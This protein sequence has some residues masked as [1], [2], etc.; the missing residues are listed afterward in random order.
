MKTH[1]LVGEQTAADLA[2]SGSGSTRTVRGTLGSVLFLTLIQGGRE[3]S[4]LE[5]DTIH[6]YSNFF[7]NGRKG[8]P[9]SGNGQCD[10]IV[11]D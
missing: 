7:F 1:C 6:V 8:N 2:G 5:N 11:D 4:R 10:F 3:R 9:K